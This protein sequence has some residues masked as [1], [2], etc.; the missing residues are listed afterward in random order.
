MS[1]DKEMRQ[2]EGLPVSCKLLRT[3]ASEDSPTECPST[4]HFPI[5]LIFKLD[6]DAFHIAAERQGAILAKYNSYV[7]YLVNAVR[8][9]VPSW[10]GKDSCATMDEIAS[11]IKDPAFEK[12]L[13]SFLSNAFY[14]KFPV[15][16]KAE[17]VLSMSVESDRFCCFTSAVLFAD[18]LTQLGKDVRVIPLP[19]HMVLAGSSF[20]FETTYETPYTMLGTVYPK[21]EFSKHYPHTLFHEFGVDKLLISAFGWTADMLYFC[22]SADDAITIYKKALEIDPDDA[23][24]LADFG[25]ALCGLKE[26]EEGYAVLKRALE[27]EPED[28]ILL[29]SEGLALLALKDRDGALHAFE[30]ATKLDPENAVA[31]LDVA[32]CLGYYGEKDEARKAWEKAYELNFILAQEWHLRHYPFIS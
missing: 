22:G 28:A 12:K 3:T 20:I 13:F 30:A 9:V 14:E 27:L 10:L 19:K 6:F 29:R 4:K 11:A 1:I 2:R 17:V 7:S 31:L 32:E 8:D 23:Y 25:A 16:Y 26:F 5:D 18:V 21:E 24:I 15:S